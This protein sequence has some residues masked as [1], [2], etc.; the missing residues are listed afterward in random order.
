M[1][2]FN[3]S[4]IDNNELTTE[5]DQSIIDKNKSIIEIN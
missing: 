4:I 1:I 3:Q 2:D 5:I